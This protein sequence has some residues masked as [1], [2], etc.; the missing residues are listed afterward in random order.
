M[1]FKRPPRGYTMEQYPLNHKFSSSFGLGATSATKGATHIPILRASEDTANAEGVEVNPRHGAFAQETGMTCFL[2]SIVPRIQFNMSMFI[3]E[4]AI[5]T[6]VRHLVVKFMPVYF[7][8][9]DS[10]QAQDDKTDIEV[11][12]VLEVLSSP[13][14]KDV[15][16][17]YGTKLFS[18]GLLPLSTITFPTEAITDWDMTT[19]A[20]YEGVAFDEGLMFDALSFHTSAGM[21]RKAMGPIRSVLVKQDRPFHYSSNNF[22]FP[23]VKRINA[24]TYCGFLIWLPQADTQGQTLL[25]SEITDIEHLHVNY[26]CRFDEWNPNFDQTE[27]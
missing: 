13:T 7:A 22:T 3:P 24:F 26:R 25:D 11:Q 5:L 16:P 27:S 18:P 10:L 8:F 4:A 17:L 19:D 2:G 1:V 23:R 15:T 9:V 21:L 6:G 14:K 12:D 20:T